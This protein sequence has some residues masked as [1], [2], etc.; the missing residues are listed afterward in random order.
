MLAHEM[1][2]GTC[3]RH[4]SIVVNIKQHMCICEQRSCDNESCMIH[5]R[6]GLSKSSQTG[7]ARC[8]DHVLLL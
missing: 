3:K 1:S 7:A 5:A 2:C 4:P 6:I 8:S